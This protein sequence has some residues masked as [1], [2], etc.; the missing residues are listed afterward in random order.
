MSAPRVLHCLRSPVG[1]LFRHVRDL[2]EAMVEPSKVISDQYRASIIET[3]QGMVITGRVVAEDDKQLTVQTNA[4]DA[5]QLAL[6]KREDIE[7][8]IPSPTSL[9]PDKLLDTLNREEMLDLLA[10]LL[11]RGNPD[12]LMFQ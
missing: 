9:M 7:E 1:G 8:M 5:S 10:Y 11:S 2:A 3:A 4:E 6:V 12:D